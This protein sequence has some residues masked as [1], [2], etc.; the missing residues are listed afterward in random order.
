[1]YSGPK[2]LQNSMTEGI[3][4]SLKSWERKMTTFRWATRRASS[5][6]A[7]GVRLLSWTPVTTEPVKGVKCL[8][9]A[10]EL[11]LGKVESASLARS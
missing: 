7:W 10:L 9:W 3:G 4:K 5:S 8:M 1:M 11:R 2:Y 6:L